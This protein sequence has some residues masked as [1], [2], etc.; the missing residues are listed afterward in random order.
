MTKPTSDRLDAYFAH[1]AAVSP[2]ALRVWTATNETE[3][4]AAVED[5]VHA[6]LLQIE[7][8]ARQYAVLEER[9]LSLLL[10]QLLVAGSLSAVAEGYHNGHV[11]VTVSHPAGLAGAMLGECKIYRGLEHHCEGCEQLLKRYSSGRSARA[12][13]LD[14]F[15]KP[16][17]Y[18]KLKKLRE[19]FDAKRPLDQLD[20]AT[21]HGIKGAFPTAH[22]HFT[23]AVV[24][25]LHL[26]C[27]VYH[28]E[29]VLPGIQEQGTDG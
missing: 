3:F 22:K 23:A 25:L 26:G 24:E 11:D 21:D 18:E 1:L 28:P 14:F 8:G 9:G 6:A 2:P 29:A 7:A 4:C 13:C 10:A 19:E 5:A 16:G 17:M 20:N 27:N 15:T 12:F